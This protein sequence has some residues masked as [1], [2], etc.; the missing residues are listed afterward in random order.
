MIICTFIGRMNMTRNLN[1]FKTNVGAI[2]Q[3][4]PQTEVPLVHIG[5]LA[6]GQEVDMYLDQVDHR[7]LEGEAFTKAESFLH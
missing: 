6:V 7:H 5:N 1:D 4:P 3:T 2:Q